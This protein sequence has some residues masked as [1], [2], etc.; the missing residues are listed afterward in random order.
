MNKAAMPFRFVALAAAC[1]LIGACS[2]I[3]IEPACPEELRVG[4][5]GPVFAN[6]ENEGAIATYKWE[7]F[8]AGAGTF[9]DATVADTMLTA[10]KKG[11]VV[12]RLTASDGLFMVVSECSTLILAPVDV[13]VSL[14]ASGTTVEAGEAVTL[15][16]TSTGDSEA[17][18]RA[19]E[20]V[21]GDVVALSD[22]SEG[23]VTFTPAAA[24]TLGFLCVGEDADGQESDPASLT[25]TVTDTPP[26]NNNDNDNDA[27]VND[28]SA[29]EGN[30]NDNSDNVPADNQNDNGGGGRVPNR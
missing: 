13:S 17:V 7:V 30:V 16:C 5:S 12:V 3:S 28:N 9:A 27:N 20:Q 29:S 22:V 11:A 1:L 25:I 2:G 10:V 18:T 14:E 4:E 6:A 21:S 24:G 26:G 19:I 15:T 8:P 23:V